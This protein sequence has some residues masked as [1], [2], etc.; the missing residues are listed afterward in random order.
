MQKSKT[1]KSKRR[2]TKTQKVRLNT[3]TS[4]RKRLAITV[5]SL[6]ATMSFLAVG[7][8]ASVAN[9]QIEVD[10]YINFNISDIEG[11][12]RY[13]RTGGIYGEDPNSLGY[14][15]GDEA[16]NVDNF[17]SDNALLYST[18]VVNQ[19]NIDNLVNTKINVN[20]QNPTITY[21]FMFARAEGAITNTKITLDTTG[22]ENLDGIEVTYNY[23][24]TENTGEAWSVVPT[25]FQYSLIS[26]ES[27]IVDQY[28]SQFWLE[29][30]LSIENSDIKKLT[31]ATWQFELIFEKTFDESEVF[32]V[33]DKN[34]NSDGKVEMI[35]TVADYEMFITLVNGGYTVGE[36]PS[37]ILSNA[38]FKGVLS[39][40]SNGSDDINRY[41]SYPRGTKYSTLAYQLES[42]LY[43]KNIN[44][45]K[46]ANVTMADSSTKVFQSP[47]AGVYVPVGT[48]TNPFEGTFT[49]VDDQTGNIYGL[50]NIYC[51]LPNT[52]NIG[53]FGVV[54]S[55]TISEFWVK[56]S[57]FAGK[58]DVGIYIGQMD[59]LNMVDS[60]SVLFNSAETHIVSSYCN[61]QT[62]VGELVGNDV[63]DMGN[64]PSDS[65]LTDYVGYLVV[66]QVNGGTAV[67][68]VVVAKNSLIKEFP[69]TSRVVN[70]TELTMQGW[71]KTSSFDPE[72]LFDVTSDAVTSNLTLYAKWGSEEYTLT[73]I[74]NGGE[75]VDITPK[76]T[77]QSHEAYIDL[78]AV[79]DIVRD[80]YNFVGW[81]DTADF[82]G[83]VVSE[84]LYP[85]SDVTLYAKWSPINYTLSYS[86][87]GGTNNENNCDQGLTTKTFTKDSNFALYVPTKDGYIFDGWYEN[88]SFTGTAVT[89]VKDRIGDFTLYAKW[90]TE[91]SV[92]YVLND[93][94]AEL[95]PATIEKVGS[96]KNLTLFAPTCDGYSFVGWYTTS[97]L[98]GSAVTVIENISSN[99]TVYA[100]WE[101]ATYN[102]TY[103][104]N[105]GTNNAS[106]LSTYTIN[107]LPRTLLAPTKTGY[108][109]AGWYYDS[110]LSTI[111]TNS[112]IPAGTYGDLN[113]YAKWTPK[114][115]TITTNAS[116]A[117][118]SNN[119]TSA[120]HGTAYTSNVTFE[121]DTEQ[122]VL[123]MMGGV[124]VTS[125]AYNSGTKVINIASVTGNLEI[126]VSSQSNNATI[127]IE[128]DAMGG[129]ISNASPSSTSVAVGSS[130]SC[131]VWFGYDGDKHVI[132][133]MNGVDVTSTAYNSS[134]EKIY[135]SNVTG[136][137]L[138]WIHSQCL[139]SDTEITVWDEKRKRKMKKKVQDIT[140][141]DL[142]LVWNFDEGKFDYAKPLW[143]SKKR[144]TNRYNLLKF[145]DGTELR[146]VNQHRVFCKELGKFVY[147]MVDFNIGY[148][149]YNEKGE[150]VKL[151]SREIIMQK[152]DYY[153][154]ITEQH[155]NCFVNG[156]LTSCRLNNM[157]KI[158]NMKFVKD[159]RKLATREEY[160]DIDDKFFYGLRLAE[161]P[162]TF[163][164]NDF[165]G[166]N[167]IKDYV[168]SLKSLMK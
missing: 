56:N 70:G 132:V 5:L 19:T 154:I 1:L 47:E 16:T 78:P 79:S 111:V 30:K 83:S 143:M 115:Y 80:G 32:S 151:V 4:I 87:N 64:F 134:T 12:L 84:I 8:L 6:V 116:G 88:S 66:Y 149:T 156:I 96:G 93:A 85:T 92:T 160:A 102:I 91:Y 138:I 3:K 90:I 29:C 57:Q 2:Y 145:S 73:F 58:A 24:F 140:Y 109:F 18:G 55:A 98:S 34:V 33:F 21:L 137:I 167:T 42:D 36:E 123:V 22:T 75:F 95:H 100:K 35:S 49:G 103:H 127:T 124:D 14:T 89:R 76:T 152:T 13:N 108:D 119:S 59:T 53:V 40:V 26:G 94:N 107:D 155:F 44:L 141:N 97:D 62:N 166:H 157:Y 142:L 150:E 60:P 48:E 23:T 86:L 69:Y 54:K 43:L 81:Y 118:L 113:L 46:Y 39:S 71:Y 114:V 99:I 147:P 65:V 63:N 28:Q 106:N 162:R 128:E 125:T 45:T 161:Q 131:D 101:I 105:D 158:E 72:S 50:E 144:T 133:T 15:S 146:T 135:I 153:N 120:Q 41:N 121:F 61:G 51:V 104:L 37:E 148:T 52:N 10:N 11:S 77:I 130:F 126:T 7:V 74:T 168:E 82:S 20:T 9:F 112:I 38:A 17:G 136:D 159:N 139:V 31:D 67:K 165:G 110:T 27:V 122:S 164:I 129:G 163:D 68:S 25:N 117:S